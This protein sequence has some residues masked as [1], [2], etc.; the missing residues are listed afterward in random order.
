MIAMGQTGYE[1]LW[2]VK[3]VAAFLQ[4]SESWVSKRAADDSLP[5]IRIG[6][7]VR[8]E[9]EAIRAWARGGRQGTTVL[10]IRSGLPNLGR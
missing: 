3:E 7:A 1:G 9:P 5:T 10:P 8:F 6:R 4:M 2:T